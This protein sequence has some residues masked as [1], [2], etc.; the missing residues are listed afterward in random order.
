MASEITAVSDAAAG[1]S[2]AKF[3][4]ALS[5]LGFYRLQDSGRDALNAFLTGDELIHTTYFKI[6]RFRKLL[7][8]SIAQSPGFRPSAALRN[9]P[10]FPLIEQWYKELTTAPQAAVPPTTVAPPLAAPAMPA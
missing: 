2:I 5:E 8:Y 4:A 1:K 10:D 9:D 7:A 3:R 6:P